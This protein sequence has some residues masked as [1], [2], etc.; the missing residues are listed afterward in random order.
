M[1]D[2]TI[3]PQLVAWIGESCLGKS[4]VHVSGNQPA[5]LRGRNPLC[6][7]IYAVQPESGGTDQPLRLQSGNSG[8]MSLQLLFRKML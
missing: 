6:N 5:T 1:S 8:T 7:V 4:V 2:S 3:Q